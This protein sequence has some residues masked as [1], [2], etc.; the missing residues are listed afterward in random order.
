MLVGTRK[1]VHNYLVSLLCGANYR[2]GRDHRRANL[3]LGRLEYSDKVTA[4]RCVLRFIS[5]REPKW[6]ISHQIPAK[7]LNQAL[8]ERLNTSL[9]S[10]LRPHAS[11]KPK[12]DL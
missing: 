2:I 4:H 8:P 11:G 10:W 3:R 1:C 6:S 12:I 5:L 7:I 9:V